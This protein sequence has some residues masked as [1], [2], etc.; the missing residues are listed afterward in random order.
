MDLQVILSFIAIKYCHINNIYKYVKKHINKNNN[1][2]VDINKII[3]IIEIDDI[4][5]N[6][7]CDTTNVN[8]T[9]IRL[10]VNNMITKGILYRFNNYYALTYQGTKIYDF[11]VNRSANKIISFFRNQICTKTKLIY[12]NI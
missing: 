7:T 10:T 12:H 4:N 1:K 5:I 3:D 6:K 2:S 11:I 8:M 9:N